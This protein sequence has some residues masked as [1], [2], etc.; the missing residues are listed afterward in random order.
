MIYFKRNNRHSFFIG[1]C[2]RFQGIG[3]VISTDN[4]V[5]YY[6]TV[7]IELRFLWLKVWY[8]YDLKAKK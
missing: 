7:S 2:R 8:C 4:P 1:V 5:I 3:F 6:E